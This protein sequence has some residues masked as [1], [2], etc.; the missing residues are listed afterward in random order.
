MI[1]QP[2]IEKDLLLC[3]AIVCHCLVN[4]TRDKGVREKVGQKMLLT[5]CK[6]ARWINVA[7][8]QFCFL[9]VSNIVKSLC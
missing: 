7:H 2:Y 4:D 1:K 3:H 6:I 5:P 8:L 9:K